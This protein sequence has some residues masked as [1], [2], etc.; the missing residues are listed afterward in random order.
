MKPLEKV[1][2]G[3][4]MRESS[5]Y[6]EFGAGG[7][8]AWAVQTPGIRKIQSVESNHDW[9][10]KLRQ[11]HDVHLAE[12]QHRLSFAPIDLGPV[13]ELGIPVRQDWASKQKWHTY[14][15]AI[16]LDKAAHWD[17]VLVD[18]RFRLACALKALQHIK[19]PATTKI[20]IHD[21]TFRTEYHPVERFADVVETA[22]TLVVLRKKAGVDEH[23]LA[24]AA[25]AA[26]Q[27]WVLMNM[28]GNLSGD[29]PLV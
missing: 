11:R 10:A 22:Q 17:L 14:S 18:G 28:T 8:T 21:Y 16:L 2:L 5:S 6:F 7:S 3:R 20:L 25:Q 19:D 24:Q 1:L 29:N 27:T 4:L 23:A 15:D 26:E 12:Q 13:K 9:V